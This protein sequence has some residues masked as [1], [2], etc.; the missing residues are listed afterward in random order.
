METSDYQLKLE[1]P[2]G[3]TATFDEMQRYGS[4][5]QNFVQETEAKLPDV[6]NIN[7][8]NEIVD[9]LNMLADS[10]NQQLRAYKAAEKERLRLCMMN[11]LSF[12]VG[13]ER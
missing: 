6:E 5:I 2:R 11:L 3:E 13:Q 10:Y 9:Y 7:E 8:Y 12:Q 4:A 1:L